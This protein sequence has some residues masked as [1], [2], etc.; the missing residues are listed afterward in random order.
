MSRY[1]LEMRSSVEKA[2]RKIR[3]A[4][5]QL[6]LEEAFN[7]LAENPR[8]MGAEKAKNKPM[9]IL[10]PTFAAVRTK[11]ARRAFAFR[12]FFSAPNSQLPRGS[13]VLPAIACREPPSATRPMRDQASCPARS[14]HRHS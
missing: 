9:A 10:S 12:R 1:R 4:K 14:N 13:S 8:R 5:R 6:R 3:D 7:K 2:L 11:W